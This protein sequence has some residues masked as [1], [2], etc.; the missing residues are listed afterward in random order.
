MSQN[1][2]EF[3]RQTRMEEAYLDMHKFSPEV[4]YKRNDRNSYDIK[5]AHKKKEVFLREYMKDGLTDHVV[6]TYNGVEENIDS[7]YKAELRANEI[8]RSK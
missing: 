8:L 6:L 1:D 2:K 5:I 4:F 7:M 3:S